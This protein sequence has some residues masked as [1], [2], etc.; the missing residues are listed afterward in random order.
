[1]PRELLG[2]MIGIRSRFRGTVERFGSKRAYR[3]PDITTILL[4]DVVHE[5]TGEIVT[6]HLWFTSGKWS[7]SVKI[8]D[9]IVFDARVGE[10]LKGYRGRRED[11]YSPMEVDYRLERPTKMR[12]V[13][14]PSDAGRLDLQIEE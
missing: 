10:Y 4:R 3:G 1:M 6:D 7:A 12:V 8:G 11:V 9:T 14:E 5:A 2:Q 13:S